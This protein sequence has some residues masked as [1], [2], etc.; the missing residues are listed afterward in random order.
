[1]LELLREHEKLVT[2]LPAIVFFRHPLFSF[3]PDLFIGFL[4]RTIDLRL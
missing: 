3:P 1:M 2:T 4:F